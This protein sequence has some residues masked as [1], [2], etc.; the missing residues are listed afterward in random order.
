ME[1]TRHW[2]SQ[3]T[4]TVKITTLRHHWSVLWF[5]EI[6]FSF[7]VPCFAVTVC[8]QTV[9]RLILIIVVVKRENKKRNL[10]VLPE[11]GTNWTTHGILLSTLR[12][13]SA[14]SAEKGRSVK[15]DKVLLHDCRRRYVSEVLKHLSRVAARRLFLRPI[16][17]AAL[18]ISGNQEVSE[19]A[20]DS[21]PG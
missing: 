5:A 16:H 1:S 9:Q 12:T 17:S 8:L 18:G 21:L 2:Q 10:L 7:A 20:E 14:L 15:C 11:K 13:Y 19:L 6:M 4:Y 3:A